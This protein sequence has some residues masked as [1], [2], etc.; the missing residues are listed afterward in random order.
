MFRRRLHAPN[1]THRRNFVVRAFHGGL[2]G[3]ID[4]ALCVRD[5]L[6]LRRP[7]LVRAIGQF[8]L[9][10]NVFVGRE[11]TGADNRGFIRKHAIGNDLQRLGE[12]NAECA[13][14]KISCKNEPFLHA[15]RGSMGHRFC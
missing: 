9:D 13:R 8:S 3:G 4:D 6:R 1:E 2:L 7:G 12:S 5:E 10:G 14:P 11:S 15:S